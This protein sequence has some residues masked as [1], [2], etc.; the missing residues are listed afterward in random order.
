MQIDLLMDFQNIVGNKH[1]VS[2]KYFEQAIEGIYELTTFLNNKTSSAALKRIYT[3]DVITNNLLI[4]K[5]I[6]N[7]MCNMISKS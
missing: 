7:N 6:F 3:K 1:S 4:S 5:N 2:K